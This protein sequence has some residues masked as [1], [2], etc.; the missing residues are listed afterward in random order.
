[1]SRHRRGASLAIG[2]IFVAASTMLAGAPIAGATPSADAVN[3]ID[4]HYTQFGGEGSPLGAPTGEA[5]DVKGGVERDYAN[6]AIFWSKESGPQAMYGEIFNKYQALGGPGGELGFPKNDEGDTGDGVGRF[7]DFTE[8][9][10]STASI[11]WTPNVGA[12]VIKGK[13][14]DAWRAAGGIK[15]PFG[16]P[17]A[18]TTDNDG[19][20]TNTFVGPDGTQIQWSKAAGLVTIPAALAAKIPGFGTSTEGTT[21]VTKPSISAPEAPAVEKKSSKWWWWIPIIL[22]L[23]GL[24]ALLPRLF[25]K[26]EPQPVKVAARAPEVKKVVTPPPPPPVKKVVAPPPPPP[27]KKVVA[28][29]P[30]PPVKKVV[31]P[32]P[33]PPAPRPFTP[34]PPK[35]VERVEHKVEQVAEKVDHKFDQVAEKFDRVSEK[36]DQK[37]DHVS[38]KADHRLEHVA[39]KADHRIEHVAEKADRFVE[40][41]KATIHEAHIEHE[42]SPVIRYASHTPAET[43]IQVTYENNAVDGVESRADKSDLTPDHLQE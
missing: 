9:D 15:S 18:D 37:L 26:P 28:P 31:P 3:A 16:Y 23:L 11:Y 7:N 17:T 38:E 40:A 14:L 13:V 1:M 10:G 35:L 20:L 42:T 34:E 22:A 29:P 6:G 4:D 32:P 21:S 12:W 2:G 5:V 36:V 25:R 39:E 30:P 43:T 27:V 8:K 19:T 33:P 41:P 24:L